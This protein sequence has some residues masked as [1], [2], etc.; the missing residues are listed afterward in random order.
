MGGGTASR[1][2]DAYRRR[3]RPAA[4]WPAAL[5]AVFAAV[6]VLLATTP[7]DAQSNTNLRNQ[8]RELRGQVQSLR[9]QLADLE[10]VVHKG[11]ARRDFGV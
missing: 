3:F 5:L 2:N 9:A 11:A 6:A 1:L 8:I 7:V 4:A 10:R